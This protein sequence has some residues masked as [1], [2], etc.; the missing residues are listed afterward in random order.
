ML[1]EPGRKLAI[2]WHFQVTQLSF[3]LFAARMKTGSVC[4][5]RGIEKSDII[6]FTG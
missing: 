2:L 1:Y 6:V 5:C 4:V 3:F